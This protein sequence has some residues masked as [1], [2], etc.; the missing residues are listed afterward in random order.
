MKKLKIFLF[1][2]TAL[3]MV[4]AITAGALAAK[5]K[6]WFQ[7]EE[8]GTDDI[9]KN[10]TTKALIESCLKHPLSLNIFAFNSYLQG[11]DAF[12]N[13]FSG[14][15]EL[16][17]RN[18]AAKELLFYY[19][20]FDY[21]EI[22]KSNDPGFTM[23][24]R[25]FNYYMSQESII[26]KLTAQERE[27]LLEVCKN[28]IMTIN[29]NYADIFSTDSI[30]Y[31]AACVLQADDVAFKEKIFSDDNLKHEMEQ[32]RISSELSELTLSKLGLNEL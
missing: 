20:D 24:V 22:A 9:F 16:L 18:D 25:F 31:L 30:I 29:E 8:A 1:I 28:H 19:K 14:S 3:I 32:G 12:N 13:H 27:D 5:N 10:M 17:Q 7:K 2:L 23:R 11:L 21:G 26:S 6:L 15:L 4:F